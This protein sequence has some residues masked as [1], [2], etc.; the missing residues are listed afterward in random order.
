MP[1]E[2]WYEMYMKSGGIS[3]KMP[4]EAWYEMYMKPWHPGVGESGDA[5]SVSSHFSVR[6]SV[7]GLLTGISTQ[8]CAT[9]LILQPL[10]GLSVFTQTANW[11]H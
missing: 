5:C 10:R 4:P 11:W 9:G 6:V 3:A 1:P 2:A 8:E 7:T